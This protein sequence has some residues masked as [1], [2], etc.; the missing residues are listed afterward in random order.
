M[1]LITIDR[2]EHLDATIESIKAL[3]VRVT[4]R[5]V[6][7]ADEEPRHYLEAC[8][9]LSDV[10]DVMGQIVDSSVMSQ[11]NV[12]S[13]THRAK[14]YLNLLR[15]YLSIVESAN[16]INGDWCGIHARVLAIQVEQA[17]VSQNIKNAVTYYL[18]GDDPEQMFDWARQNPL[19]ASMR[20]VSYYPL[21]TPLQ[22]RI[23]M[24]ST[25]KRLGTLY[26]N[27]ALGIG[28]YGTENASG[29]NRATQAQKEALITVMEATREV[30]N[31][32]G[33]G[34]YWD[35]VTDISQLLPIFQKVWL[36]PS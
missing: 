7:D 8:K 36:V 19:R 21:T 6:F 31:D 35:W 1:R 14:R 24:T 13:I 25:L 16:E 10:C 3:P 32:I 15:P 11:F 5:L 29:G 28:E 20:L 12:N 27:D 23:D 33:G 26:P 22:P 2:I 4:A 9:R 34:G 18:D 30:A 17:C